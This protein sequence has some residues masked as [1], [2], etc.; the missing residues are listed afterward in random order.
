MSTKTSAT[1]KDL[2]KVFTNEEKMVKLTYDFADMGGTN[3]DVFNLGQFGAKSLI[4][5]SKVHVETACAGAT[6][7]VIIG[8]TSDADCFMDITAGA[9]ANLADDYAVSQAAGQASVAQ[10]DDYIVLDIGTASLTAGK[11]NV[12]IWYVNVA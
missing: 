3:T 10:A 12:Y 4:T 1:W 6:A 8:T 7:T 11:I 9:I 5:K 2:D